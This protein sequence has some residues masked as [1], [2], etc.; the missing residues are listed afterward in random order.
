MHRILLTAHVRFTIPQF[1]VFAN[2][3]VFL[4]VQS[5]TEQ[6][7]FDTELISSHTTIVFVLQCRMG[8]MGAVEGEQRTHI[9]TSSIM[10]ELTWKSTIL[11]KD[12]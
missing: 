9:N 12:V 3:A 10:E 4:P 6:L 1:I 8:T 2:T 11:S 7:L 5:T